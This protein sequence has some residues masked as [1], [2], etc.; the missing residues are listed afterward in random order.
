MTMKTPI[1]N[2]EVG[3]AGG[4]EKKDKKYGWHRSAVPVSFNTKAPAEIL[5]SA[6]ASA[7]EEITGTYSS[8]N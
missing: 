5:T 6:S 8:R 7:P 3:P 1:T 2:E 4:S